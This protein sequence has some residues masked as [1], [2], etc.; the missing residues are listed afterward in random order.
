M[1]NEE[2]MIWLVIAGVSVWLYKSSSF[3]WK[4]VILSEKNLYF[5]ANLFFLRKKKAKKISFAHQLY[6]LSDSWNSF[7]QIYFLPIKVTNQSQKTNIRVLK[8][9]SMRHFDKTYKK[10]VFGF[11]LYVDL[12]GVKNQ[13]QEPNTSPTR[14]ACDLFGKQVHIC[15][16]W[17]KSLFS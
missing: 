17:F 1:M 2:L 13:I 8:R 7:F 15:C 3:R 11:Q 6:N 10:V 14:L 16:L 9:N 5:I 12:L 4:L